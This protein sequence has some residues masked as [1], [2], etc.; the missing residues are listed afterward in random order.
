MVAGAK[1]VVA[2]VVA[3]ARANERRAAPLKGDELTE[4]LL[5][6]AAAAAGKLGKE[7]ARAFLLGAG[8]A[9]DSSGMLRTNPL[10]R[11][12]WRRVESDEER[13]ARLKA[14]GAPP[15]HGRHD[16]CQ[17]FAVSAA[18]T[19]VGGAKAAEAAG[20]LKEL[21]DA[22]PGGS[23]FSFADLAADYSGVAFASRLIDKPARLAGVAKGCRIADICLAPKGL[24]EDLSRQDFEKK[25]GDTKDK[26]FL[27]EVQALRKKIAALPGHKDAK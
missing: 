18:L 1:K 19:A 6:S 13:K 26:R 7:K 16:L 17:H 24:A 12:L 11:G 10:T 2:A 14:V 22:E 5:Q 9:L 15:M 20:L 23:G 4:H 25:Y 21:L 27:T 8:V 3:A